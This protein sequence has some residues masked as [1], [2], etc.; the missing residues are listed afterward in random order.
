MASTGG[1]NLRVRISADLADIKQGLGLLRGVLAKVKTDAAKATPDTGAWSRGIGKIRAELGN[2]A[3][4]YVGIQTIT[5]GIGALF[6]S[7]DRQDRIGELAVQ[8][9]I[10]TEALSRM[11]YG[12]QFSGVQIE[13]LSDSV[14]KFNRGLLTN[15]SLLKQLGIDTRDA[16]G[17][18]RAADQII[19]ELADVFASLPDGP[20]RAALAVKLFGK[21]G[22][23][24]IPFLVEG[25]AKL[26]EYGD[27]AEATGNV[28]NGAAAAAAGEFNDNLGR[29]KGT[30]AGL[31]NETV[32]NVIPAMSGY[33]E[34]AAKAGATSNFAAEGGQFLANILKV[35][36]AGG[37]IVKN[38]I[39]GVVNV[40]AFLHDAAYKT[41]GML[42][43]SLVRSFSV[44]VD[45]GKGLLTGKNPIEVFA[46][47]VQQGGAAIKQNLKGVSDWAGSIKSG[48]KSMKD[49][50]ADAATDI[51]RVGKLWDSAAASAT[52]GAA[53]VKGATEGVS[54]A[55]QKL[56]ETLR[57][58]L[59]DDGKDG[60]SKTAK[61]IEEL[62]A[63]TAL[64]QDQVKRAQEALDN[65]FDDNKKKS[66]Q[67]I[68]DYYAKRV[69]LQQRLIDLQI[70]QA[71][72]ELGVTKELGQRRQ[73]EE[74]IIILQRDRAQ[75]GIDA[76][77]EQKKAE[78][79]LNRARQ[80]GFDSRLSGLTGSLSASE[81]S[82]SAQVDAGSLGMGEG[83]RRLQAVRTKTL[84]QLRTLRAEQ[85]AYFAQLAPSSPE[86]AGAQQT[87]L[88][89]DTAIAN[90]TSSM[91]R[92]RQEAE[93]STASALRNAFDNI[94]E[95]AMSAL[96]VVRTLIA[97]IA[98]GLFNSATESLSKR[99]ASGI[100]SLF[101]KAADKTAD[102]AA[103]TAGAT[104][105]AT[106]QTTAATTSATIL[107]TGAT[108]AG[109]QLITAATTAANIMAAA[110]AISSFGAAHGGGIA[111][112]L[113]MVRNNINPMVFG[114][115]PRYHGGGI[116][117]LR[118]DEIPAILQ[119]GEVIRTRQQERALQA[120]LGAGQGGAQ[121]IRNII[122]FSDAELAA[123]L[124]GAAGEQVVVNHARRNRGA[125]GG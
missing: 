61:K 87:L 31:A 93:D 17:N 94:K 116:A 65:A 81:G 44:V 42:L 70:E 112:S 55:T 125:I 124:E 13:A 11:A 67:D 74:Q 46:T 90:V 82:I 5:R 16:A 89:I 91:Q 105:A 75:V 58:L 26:K 106:I 107:Q 35:V 92:F 77:R 21:S 39:E 64:L 3:G 47:A 78:E 51:G 85:A 10:S 48:F 101:G 43:G 95:G 23:D 29:L 52:K 20:E 45:A 119:R 109:A 49:G 97:D 57:K 121:P 32:K 18:F 22:A 53:D 86:Y 71:Q 72:S 28:I 34:D 50:V 80:E 113:R 59:G 110:N 2:L 69:E 66:P 30:L 63:S 76:A 7:L 14:T 38:V 123:A 54:P 1:A 79:E 120:R 8:S 88:G 25:K 114:A 27:Q 6:D 102:V 118:N 9:G 99:A 100:A 84:E 56:L 36:A 111:G 37:I 68:A 96:D 115:A 98:D 73:L 122:V 117:G 108:I 40:L 41:A 19:G 4:A 83:E 15:E 24:I 103:E 60:K 33:A 104:A 12:A 62:G